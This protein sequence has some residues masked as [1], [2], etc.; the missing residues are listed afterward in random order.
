MVVIKKIEPITIEEFM[1]TYKDTRCQFHNGDVWDE[2][3]PDSIRQALSVPDHSYVQFCI[4]KVLGSLFHRSESPKGPGGW[5]FFDEVAVKYGQASLFIH[6]LAGWKRA[7]LP[8]R[9]R[10][11]PISERPDWVC[12]ILSTNST[13]DRITK[14]A[15]LHAHEVPYYWIVE[16]QERSI[17]VLEWSEKGYVSILDVT[18][19]FVGR[20]PPFDAVE[21][22][23]N[24]LF[25]EE[26]E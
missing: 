15:T 25:G 12:E 11:Y 17:S 6:D 2:E 24:V 7:R 19:G 21:L 10:R 13:N 20:I 1:R 23:A 14:K 26:D 16:P 4:G 3:S 18:E 9:P 22:K 8:E 5:W